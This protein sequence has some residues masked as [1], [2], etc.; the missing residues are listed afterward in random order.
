[1]DHSGIIWVGTNGLDKYNPKKEKF[2][3]YDYVPF[4]REKLIFRNIHPIY[5]DSQDVLWIGSKADGLHVLDRKSHSYLHIAHNPGNANSLSS[6]HVRFI[7][8]FPEGVLWVATEDQG[9][10]KIYLDAGRKPVRYKSYSTVDQIRFQQQ[11]I[12][13]VTDNNG[14]FG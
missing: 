2:V 3:L 13:P 10:D 8:E 11:N 6:N 12:L 14:N 4:T 9:L 7:K 5:E 1:M